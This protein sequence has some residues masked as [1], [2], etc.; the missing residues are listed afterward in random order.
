MHDLLRDCEA[1]L[2]EILGVSLRPES[3]EGAARLPFYLQD[4]YTFF[5]ASLLGVDCLLMLDTGDAE[6]SPATLRKQISQ[7]QKS[8]DGGVIYVRKSLPAYL[9]KRLIEQRIAFVIPGKQ[10]YLPPVGVDFREFSQAKRPVPAGFS[11]S[12]QVVILYALLHGPEQVYTPLQL[13]QVLH[14]SPMTMTR[15]LDEIEQ[16]D[17]ADVRREGKARILQFRSGSMAL[18]E[19]LHDVLQNPVRKRIW[20]MRQP[21]KGIGLTAGLS[22][23]ASMTALAAPS[24]PVYA[25]AGEE[26]Q[27]LKK[28]NPNVELT[29]ADGDAGTCE[30]EVWSYPP[31]LL[32]H[33]ECVDPLSLYLSLQHLKDERVEAALADMMENMAW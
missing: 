18:W 13:S 26:W 31:K 15:A 5:T 23:L 6:V 21:V 17:A 16:A 32:A 12:T 10:M 33:G 20:A 14:Y 4:A 30:V 8:W 2:Q 19:Q 3:W 25:V 22:A 11:P 1:Y 7:V 24:V 28:Q 27:R 9:R 29:F